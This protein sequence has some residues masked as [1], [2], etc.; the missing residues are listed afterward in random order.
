MCETRTPPANTVVL[1]VVGGAEHKPRRVL[2][3]GRLCS[4]RMWPPPRRDGLDNAT[5]EEGGSG[6][7]YDSCEGNSRLRAIDTA[8][9]ALRR[10][11]ARRAQRWTSERATAHD[12]HAPPPELDVGLRTFEFLLRDDPQATSRVEELIRAIKD[13]EKLLLEG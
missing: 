7:E 1:L 12:T 10:R 3:R 11:I 2:T 9:T 8:S 13:K 6:A 5:R 4:A